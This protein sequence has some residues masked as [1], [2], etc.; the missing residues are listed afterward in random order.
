MR[1]TPTDDPNYR[2]RLGEAVAEGV[3]QSP[4]NYLYSTPWIVAARPRLKNLNILPS[5]IRWEGVRVE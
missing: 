4:T 2:A 3:A 5:Q 1:R